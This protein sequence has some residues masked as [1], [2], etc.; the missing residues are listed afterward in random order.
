[1]GAA[2]C[3]EDAILQQISWS[4]GSYHLFAR[5]SSVFCEPQPQ[6]LCCR[7]IIWGQEPH[8]QFFSAFGPIVAFYNGPH[9][10]K[11]QAFWWG[12][13]ATVSRLLCSTGCVTWLG[14]EVGC[15]AGRIRWVG[16]RSD[17]VVFWNAACW[18]VSVLLVCYYFKT[19]IGSEDKEWP[20]P[21]PITTQVS[22]TT[23]QC[24]QIKHTCAL[25]KKVR[26]N[27]YKLTRIRR[28]GEDWHIC[29]HF[30][31]GKFCPLTGLRILNATGW[32]YGNCQFVV[33]AVLLYVVKMSEN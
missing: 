24:C 19:S 27:K 1:M 29:E 8:D 20:C 31:Q 14:M 12:V 17:S 3:T 16:H 13:R 5:S 25:T 4:S 18:S 21:Y 6:G 22:A 23:K 2:P 30:P 33:S 15:D 10:L 7:C 28:R 11:S 32:K 26:F 9:F